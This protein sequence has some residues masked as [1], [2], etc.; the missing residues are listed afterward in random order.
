[1]LR[2]VEA[3]ATHFQQG[4]EE[5]SQLAQ[6]RKE[7]SGQVEP[8]GAGRWKREGRGSKMTLLAWWVRLGPSDDTLPVLSYTSWS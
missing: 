2:L 4:H 5:L 1:M 6:Y 8:Q 7:L 3:Q